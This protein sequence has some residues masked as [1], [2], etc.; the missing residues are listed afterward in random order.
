MRELDGVAIIALARQRFRQ[1]EVEDFDLPLGSDLDIRRLEIAMDD[2]FPVRLLER[3]RDLLRKHDGLFDRDRT[4]TETLGARLGSIHR[5]SLRPRVAGDFSST[6]ALRT[7]V[8][9]CGEERWCD[10]LTRLRVATTAKGLDGDVV[11]FSHGSLDETNV[12]F[13]DAG[14]REAS[15]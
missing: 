6:S 13:L 2:A 1:P 11:A 12:F 9:R 14:Q 8:K 15:R 10:D 4:A 5:A 7:V 3:F